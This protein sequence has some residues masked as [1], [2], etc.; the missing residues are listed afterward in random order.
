MAKA[1]AAPVAK[2][3]TPKRKTAER[4][5]LGRVLK[6]NGKVDTTKPHD[7][8]TSAPDR[9][10]GDRA[11]RDPDRDKVWTRDSKEVWQDNGGLSQRELIE[12]SMSNDRAARG[13]DEPEA[14]PAKKAATK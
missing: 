5:E 10:V 1:S 2:A 8:A 7:V 13:E 14:K 11:L 12:D 9:D 4:D 3:T 6:E